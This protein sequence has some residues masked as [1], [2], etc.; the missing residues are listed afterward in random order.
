MFFQALLE[1]RKRYTFVLDRTCAMIRNYASHHSKVCTISFFVKSSKC[2]KLTVSRSWIMLSV[3]WC[4][5]N[6]NGLY[7]SLLPL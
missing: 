6:T 4:F 7:F 3:L 1:E 5:E 2:D